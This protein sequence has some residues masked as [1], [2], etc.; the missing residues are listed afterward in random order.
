[1]LPIRLVKINVEWQNSSIE[2][3]LFS[4]LCRRRR[5][6]RRRLRLSRQQ[7]L[8]HFSY[9]LSDLFEEQLHFVLLFILFSLQ[10]ILNDQHLSLSPDTNGLSVSNLHLF[11]KRK[12][13]VSIA[14]MPAE[15]AKEERLYRH[16]SQR[17][18]STM[19]VW[20]STMS[21][22]LGRRKDIYQKL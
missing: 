22:R 19:T 5:E 3:K 2:R 16:A 14:D 18:R 12:P 20:M 15:I 13:T 4:R 11:P 10:M 7:N 9:S 17:R 6:R 21:R 8:F 1:M